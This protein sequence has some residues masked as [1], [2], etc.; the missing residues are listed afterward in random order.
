[1][2]EHDNEL[3]SITAA[4]N[5]FLTLI[6]ISCTM[7]RNLEHQI[8]LFPVFPAVTEGKCGTQLLWNTEL[9]CAIRGVAIDNIVRLKC[10]NVTAYF[11]AA[12]DH[13]AT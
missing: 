13:L 10:K 5:K 1:V 9:H 2:D 3:Y 11:D 7:I 6:I 4:C 12:R 8:R